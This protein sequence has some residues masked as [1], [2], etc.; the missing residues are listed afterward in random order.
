MGM[1]NTGCEGH[2]GCIS[3]EVKKTSNTS[4]CRTQVVKNMLDVFLGKLERQQKHG[5][6]DH[7]LRRTYWMYFSGS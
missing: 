7:R 1:Q 3:R 4:G 6:T 2:I 5:D